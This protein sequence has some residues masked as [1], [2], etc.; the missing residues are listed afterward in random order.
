[1]GEGREEM[2][3]RNLRLIVHVQCIML[4]RRAHSTGYAGKGYILYMY[5]YGNSLVSVASQAG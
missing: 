3:S 2:G 4:H 1:M 5:T